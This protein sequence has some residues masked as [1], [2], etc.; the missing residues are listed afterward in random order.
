MSKQMGMI[1]KGNSE[2]RGI[3][4]EVRQDLVLREGRQNYHEKED[5]LLQN[6]VHFFR[7]CCV[8]VRCSLR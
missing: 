1:K 7:Y 6:T 3:F 4:L 5:C 8:E 2:P